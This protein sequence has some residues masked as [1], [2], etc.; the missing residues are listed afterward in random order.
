MVPF[1]S[2]SAISAEAEEEKFFTIRF[3]SQPG[4]YQQENWLNGNEVHG[5]GNKSINN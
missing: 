3:F 1:K 4:A 2:T 5:T